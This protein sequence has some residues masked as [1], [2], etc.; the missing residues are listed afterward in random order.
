VKAPCECGQAYCLA[1]RRRIFCISA[2]PFFFLSLLIHACFH[3]SEVFELVP[4]PFPFPPALF[5][6]PVLCSS[7]VHVHADHCHPQLPPSSAFYNGFADRLA[8]PRHKCPPTRLPL[9]NG[10]HLFSTGSAP[11]ALEGLQ[12]FFLPI[13]FFSRS[14]IRDS[15][16]LYNPTCLSDRN[17]R[18]LLLPSLPPPLSSPVAFPASFRFICKKSTGPYSYHST[19]LP[20][21]PPFFQK[22]LLRTPFFD[23]SCFHFSP[24]QTTLSGKTLTLSIRS[25][26]TIR[27]EIFTKSCTSFLPLPG[28]FPPLG[29]RTSRYI[30]S[31]FPPLPLRVPSFTLVLTPIPRLFSNRPSTVL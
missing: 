28:C 31:L 11:V 5:L 4:L 13:R 2:S 29:T 21:F 16:D 26:N 14:R 25:L 30:P 19:P 10:D 9:L 6:R 15:Q 22:N 24:L 8:A 23:F 17:R 27:V 7:V 1:E 18:R 12:R 20:P 3:G